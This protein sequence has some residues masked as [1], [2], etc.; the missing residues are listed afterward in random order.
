MSRISRVNF[1]RRYGLR[2]HAS[3]CSHAR[4]SN[5]DA[6]TY[7]RARAHPRAI[8]EYDREHLQPKEW[9]GP[10]M[11]PRAKV[12][13]LRETDICS[14]PDLNKIVDPGVLSNPAVVTNGKQPRI[15]HT[16]A[17]LEH[18]TAFQLCSKAAKNKSSNRGERQQSTTYDWRSDKKPQCPHGAASPRRVPGVVI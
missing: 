18:N 7:Q 1:K 17:G 2:N 5:R 15:F 12:S 14:N 11:I 6:G 4:L 13:P 9:V 16:Y 8:L 10:V 3:R